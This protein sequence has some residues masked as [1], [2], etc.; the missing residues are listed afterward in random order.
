MLHLK[1]FSP[2]DGSPPR[3]DISLD[4]TGTALETGVL[5][6]LFLD[7]RADADDDVP[8]GAD[9]RGFW[10]DVYED[11]DHTGS[12]LWLLHRSKTIPDVIRDAQSFAEDALEWMLRD[13]V[14][15]RIQVTV[16]RDGTY[17]MRLTAVIDA[18]DGGRYQNTWRNITFTGA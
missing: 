4:G 17:T 10:A 8:K 16:E 6:S 15:S 18:P 3:F 5:L 13:G 14:A 11:N 7:R 1:S 2:D 12:K 9:R